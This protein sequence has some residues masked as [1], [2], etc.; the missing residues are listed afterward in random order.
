V[1]KI[2]ENAPELVHKSAYGIRKEL[3]KWQICAERR[4]T[5]A[6]ISPRRTAEPPPR[7]SPDFPRYLQQLHASV[8]TYLAI[9][10]GNPK[11]AGD[12]M[13]VFLSFIWDMRQAVG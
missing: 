10:V 11:D 8:N 6:H 3:L 4:R 9:Q 1:R 7:F 12:A 13:L 2:N 5:T